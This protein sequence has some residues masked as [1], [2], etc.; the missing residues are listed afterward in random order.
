MEGRG[1]I[2]DD[3]V[4]GLIQ[5]NI[6]QPECRTGFILDGFPRNVKQAEKLDEMLR[7]SGNKVDKVLDF[8]VP[9]AK[10]VSLCWPLAHFFCTP[11]EAP[12]ACMQLQQLLLRVT[13]RRWCYIYSG[14]ASTPHL[15]PV[16]F[17]A[18]QHVRP[19]CIHPFR[20]S[21][22]VL[23]VVKRRPDRI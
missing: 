1:L 16:Y 6:K 21:L 20:S 9:D 8:V 14:G 22:G 13:Q 15:L 17:P 3:I 23:V 7:H 10:L 12:T 2:S 5:E 19:T 11:D 4:V 18:R